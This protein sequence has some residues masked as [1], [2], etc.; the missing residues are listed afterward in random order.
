MKDFENLKSQWNAQTEKT[1]P[2]NGASSII[3][4]VSGIK[5]KQR[6]TNIVLGTTIAIL[7]VFAIYIS[8]YRETT[9]MIALALM[10]GILVI[11]IVAEMAS[12]SKLNR[13]NPTQNNENYKN[14]M[15]N[16]YEKRKIVHYILTPILILIYC[17]GFIMLMPYFKSSLSK[18]FYTYIQ[19]S[20][21]VVLLVLGT[22]ICLQ[23][24]KEMGVL[25]ELKNTDT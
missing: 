8:A 7:L 21:I 9:V 16:Y 10:I 5:A 18:G 14:N 20:S 15:V 23:I 2:D 6:I 24:K 19:V 1:V 12:I 13:L 22:F 25:K 4:K 17:I 3:K 11:R